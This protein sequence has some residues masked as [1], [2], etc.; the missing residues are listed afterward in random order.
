MARLMVNNVDP[1]RMQGWAVDNCKVYVD[2][3]TYDIGDAE[4]LTY[5]AGTTMHIGR[6][7]SL[8]MGITFVMGGNHRHDWMTTY[9][10]GHKYT[11]HLGGEGIVGH[12]ASKGDIVI[13]NDV[14]I[15]H[16]AKIMSGVK[17]ADGA[18]IATNALII[19]DV[20][21]YEIVGGNPQR[22]IGFRFE[23]EIIALLLE[24]SWW[25]LP[26]EF[27]REIAPALS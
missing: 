6:Y 13:G 22:H 23:P 11:E 3:Y 8:A 19:K 16:G 21:P 9:P 18:V 10:F 1:T 7:C 12:P 17:I 24:L 2:R 26:V 4:I 27:V 20:K 14:W 15:A 25:T 5:G